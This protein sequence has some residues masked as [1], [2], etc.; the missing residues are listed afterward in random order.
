MP[1]EEQGWTPICASSQ[2]DIH[3]TMQAISTTSNH[4]QEGHLM[5]IEGD[6]HAKFNT[7]DYFLAYEMNLDTQINMK[8]TIST[9][10]MVT[11]TME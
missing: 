5:P 2:L 1:I 3:L 8:P 11:T 7:N 4:L 9:K 10:L 6:E